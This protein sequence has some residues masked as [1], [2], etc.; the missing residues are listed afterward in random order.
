MD[1][2]FLGAMLEYCHFE[3]GSL[4]LKTML[5]SPFTWLTCHKTRNKSIKTK[6]FCLPLL[7]YFLAAG[8][9]I[10]PEMLCA[11][12]S[13]SH[14]SGCHGNSGGP[15][16]CQDDLGQWVLQGVA[17]WGS[18]ECDAKSP[19]TVLARVAKFR[20]WVDSYIRCKLMSTENYC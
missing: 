2:K 16:V 14:L 18:D 1:Q 15:Y 11:N 17:S 4:A 20:T 9:Q 7:V 10:T 19:F 5:P 6:F 13:G 12:Q 8:L 3:R